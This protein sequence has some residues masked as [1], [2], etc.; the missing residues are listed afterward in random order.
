MPAQ[1][2]PTEP[3]KE[4]FQDEDLMTS[5]KILITTLIF[6]VIL[7][8]II[9]PVVNQMTGQTMTPRDIARI[10]RQA[11]RQAK[12]EAEAKL[13]AEMAAKAEE[14][15]K[16]AAE[17]LA[18][19]PVDANGL[20]LPVVLGEDGKPVLGPDGRPILAGPDGKPLPEGAALPPTELSQEEMGMIELEEGESLE[21]IKAKL[22][23]KK[24]SI[25]IDM[26][27]TAN[28]YDDKVAL[29]RFLVSEDSG[30]VATVMKNLIKP[31]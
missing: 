12:A 14:E 31:A 20:P 27:N 28:S 4:W 15:A 10:E 16:K 7:V 9:R 25:S 6:L 13:A 17:E 21:D 19:V 23:P 2:A 18:K 29:I 26:L 3:P 24:S 22:K 5:V 1:F 8:T 11:A 30:R